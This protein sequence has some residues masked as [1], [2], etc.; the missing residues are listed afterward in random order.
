MPSLTFQHL[1]LTLQNFW[2]SKGCLIW[3]PHNQVV[4]AGTMNP[5]TFLRVL[6]PEPWN[7]AYVEPSARPDDGRFGQNPNRL[8][9]HTQF[10][11][12]LKPSPERSQELYLE[13]LRAIGV[14]LDKHDIRFVE[15]NWAQPTIGAWGLGWEVWLDGL[16]ITQYTYFQ[17]VGGLPLDPVC[18][19]LTYGLER[20]A[21]ALQG[22]RSVFD[23]KWDATRTYGDVKL[24]DEQE[25]S[26]YAFN[27]ADVE[28]LHELFE[29]YERECKRTLERGLV[30]PSHDYVLQASNVFNLLDTRGAI[31]VTERARYIGRMRDL[32]R[33]VATKYVAQR[34]ALGYPWLSA[35]DKVTR[36]QGDKASDVTLSP[37]HLVSP[38]PLLLELGTEELPADNVA[39][40]EAQLQK[41]VLDALAA[42]RIAHGEV[43]TIA[44]P[45]R[46]AIVVND[47]APAQQSL[48]EMVK[49]PP[50]KA[51][52][53]KDSKPTQAAIGFAKRFGLDASALVVQDDATGSYVFA[54]KQEMGKPTLDV[55]TQVLPQVIGKIAFEKTMRWN[56]SNIAF[57]RPINWMVA[58]LGDA[59]IPFAFA[60]VQA[61]RES[62][63]V[64][65]NGSPRFEIAR[66]QDYAS[67]VKRQEII[68]DIATRKAAIKQQIDALAATVNGVVA[69]DEDLLDEVTNLV[70]Q[71][72]AL[73][74]SF[75]KEY[76]E[77]PAPVLT[78]VMS[79]KQRYF[80]VLSP[81]PDGKGQGVGLLPYFI[82]VANGN[83]VDADAVR[84]GNEAVVNARFADAAYFYREDIRRP[85]EAYL[86]RLDTITFQGKLGS[87]LDKT[88]RIESL[89]EP[90]AGQ[91]QV[92][93][94]ELQVAK[95]A[96]RL[97][98]A[99]LAT[100]MVVE[101][102][103]LQGTMGRAYYRITSQD[104]DTVETEAVAQAI[105]E[106]YLPRYAGD[107]TAKSDAGLA[108]ALADKLDSIA[109]LFAVGLAPKGNADP[110]ALRRAAIGI[111]QNLNASGK[112]FSVLAGLKSAMAR[113]PVPM[114]TD[115]LN[116][117]HAFILE[118]ER[119][120][121]LDEGYKYDVVEAVI[122]EQGDN[123]A[124]AK[125][126]VIALANAV[127]HESWP[128]T[129]AAY[130]RCARII[131]S[132]TSTGHAQTEDAD[133]SAVALK[134]AV[135]GLTKPHD[136]PSLMSNLQSLTFPI[137]TFFDN[138]MVMS[139][140]PGLRAARLGLL[141]RIVTQADGIADLS[142]LEGF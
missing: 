83:T 116:A 77:I 139:D 22:V 73:L 92:A 126:A 82:T 36:R 137:T 47:V 129:L 98:K 94:G 6:G 140:D 30:L 32:A 102:T 24:Q 96:A 81:S 48:D 85:L 19:E 91:L 12:I 41:N 136:I 122:A 71:P 42:N 100:N 60:G 11:V 10:Q 135:D 75:P 1:I 13:S 87:M 21:M 106:H 119:V 53:D 78:S 133:P 127:K 89:V 34:E 54:R 110:F 58:L 67:T 44:T 65:G 125:A 33:E 7:V 8:Y 59:V 39:V 62:T 74:C 61:G 117:A 113:L 101:I 93:R 105:Y 95:K 49:G 38:S 55:L 79:K 27:Q 112:S 29:K 132:Q 104:A 120:Q 35:D 124:N 84:K 16:E 43:T 66:A 18:L 20:I 86:P 37:S 2:A 131:K 111:V 109:G 15:D 99:D 134:Q 115:A 4:G 46:T 17:Q 141:Q 103:A 107:A 108:V 68:G 9:T 51:A 70:E 40:C 56:D 88:R 14:D 25:R 128:S 76:L 45:R 5:A 72:M 138:V 130:A 57:A 80:T 118:R 69:H 3:Q 64:R 50:A 28:E 123:P 26:E 52:F 121:L 114:S 31:G 90:I 97:S 23:L 63:G 142:K